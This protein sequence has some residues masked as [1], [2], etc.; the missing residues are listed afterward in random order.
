MTRTQIQLPDPLYRRLKEL[1]ERHDWSLAEAVRRGV[2]LLIHSY[3]EA[4]A[5]ASA[6]KLPGPFDFG[7]FKAPVS[8][9]RQ[10]ANERE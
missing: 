8:D 10:L 7:E 3:P 1:A 6:W 2:E 9:W 5:S 4:P